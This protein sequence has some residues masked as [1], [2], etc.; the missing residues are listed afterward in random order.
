MSPT[1]QSFSLLAIQQEEQD[2]ADRSAKK[3]TKSLLEI[4]EEE[5]KARVAQAQEA[6]FM[7][8]W[9]EEEARIAKESGGSSGSGGAR[10]GARGGRGGGREGA[11]RVPQ[12]GKG[13]GRG[14]GGVGG[15][16]GRASGTDEQHP[17]QNVPG[18]NQTPRAPKRKQ[19]QSLPVGGAGR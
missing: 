9:Q 2:F 19:A 15:G 3:P 12:R 4:Q 5:Q 13:E 10:G 8:W 1:A 14:R 11:R 16:R 17:T 6:E 18:H 7:R